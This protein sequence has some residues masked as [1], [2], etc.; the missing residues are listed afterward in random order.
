ML[1]T[2]FRNLFSH[3]VEDEFELGIESL[4]SVKGLTRLL[5]FVDHDDSE[6][7]DAVSKCLFT[8]VELTQFQGLLP[9][10]KGPL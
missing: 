3:F 1:Q 8:N 7:A 4:F 5:I 6:K 9:Q 2:P 10:L